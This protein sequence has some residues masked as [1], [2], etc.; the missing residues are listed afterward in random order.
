MCINKLWAI[1]MDQSKLLELRNQLSKK[2]KGTEVYKSIYAQIEEL[3]LPE[4]VKAEPKLELAV[5]ENKQLLT[6][7]NVKFKVYREGG[8][9]ISTHATKLKGSMH[10]NGFVYVEAYKMMLPFIPFAKSLYPVKFEG[11]IHWD[12]NIDLK[13][14]KRNFQLYGSQVPEEFIGNIDGDGNV[15][16]TMVKSSFEWTGEHYIHKLLFDPFNG[17]ESKRSKFIENTINIKK[18]INDYLDNQ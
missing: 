13:V 12:G 7:Q 9:Y 1:N 6:N 14:S 17:D 10:K 18:S 4:L 2:R 11:Q 16:I 3:I 5:K 8:S 15:E